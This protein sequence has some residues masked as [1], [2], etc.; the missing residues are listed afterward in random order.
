LPHF[1]I[2]TGEDGSICGILKDG[3]PNAG[4]IRLEQ[5][6]S[7]VTT[8]FVAAARN[9]EQIGRQETATDRRLYGVQSF[10]MSLSGLEA[11]ANTYFHLRAI[12]LQNEAMVTRIKQT[13]GSLTRKL[14]D[15]LSL[16]GDG[17]IVDQDHLVDRIW[18]LSQLRNDTLHPRWEPSHLTVGSDLAVNGLVENRQALFE[19]GTL[20]REAMLW[21]LLVV[22][23]VGQLRGGGDMG[24]FLFHWTGN[25]G[26]TLPAILEQLA[27]PSD[28]AA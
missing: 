17:R 24:A 2:E 25:Y 18:R 4:G 11:F 16:A 7:V 13:H 10:V 5:V 8:Y 28:E 15:L 23:R 26:L 20:C 3:E 1:H 14:E 22:A 12:E 21:C 27:L 19:D 9:L 6:F